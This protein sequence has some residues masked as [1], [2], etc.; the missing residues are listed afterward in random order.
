MTMIGLGF[1]SI[2][3]R[4]GFEKRRYED[5]LLSALGTAQ[6]EALGAALA[7]L[8]FH[9]GGGRAGQARAVYAVTRRILAEMSA[10][11]EASASLPS[12]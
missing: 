11:S 1:S 12:P 6:A 8:G 7:G 10:R 4:F 3:G 2:G 9:G 5:P